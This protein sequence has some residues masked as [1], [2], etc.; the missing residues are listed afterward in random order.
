MPLSSLS[1]ANVGMHEQGFKYLVHQFSKM[2][3]K[4]LATNREFEQSM[5]L[6]VSRNVLSDEAVKSLAELLCKFE[7]FRSLSMM[8]VRPRIGRKDTGFIELAKALRENKSLVELDLRDNEISQ[9][10]V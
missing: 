6:D 7:G 9:S 10:S 2:Q 8:S 5:H 3:Q 4:A 1:V